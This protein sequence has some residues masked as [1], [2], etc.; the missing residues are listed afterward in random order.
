[1]PSTHSAGVASSVLLGIWVYGF[2]CLGCFAFIVLQKATP[3]F[4][5]NFGAGL[6]DI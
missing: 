4:W 5:V 3:N 6:S 2:L 1:V